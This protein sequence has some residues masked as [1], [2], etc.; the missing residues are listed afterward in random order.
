MDIFVKYSDILKGKGNPYHDERGRFASGPSSGAGGNKL[1]NSMSRRILASMERPDRKKY[2][3][4][5]DAIYPTLNGKQW[6]AKD[7]I[8]VARR[9]TGRKVASKKLAIEA[10]KRESFRRL[11]E[12]D[13]LDVARTARPW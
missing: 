4:F 3:D 8:E 6:K 13:L 7:V 9:V 2:K 12:K 10:I 1:V 5:F 11:R